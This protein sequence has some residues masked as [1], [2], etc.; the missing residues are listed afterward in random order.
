MPAA[1]IAMSKNIVIAFSRTARAERLKNCF[2][3]DVYAVLCLLIG[4]CLGLYPHALAIAKEMN[5]DG[6]DLLSAVQ[7]PADGC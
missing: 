3:P 6:Y 1:T 7:V 2:A 5:S 4:F